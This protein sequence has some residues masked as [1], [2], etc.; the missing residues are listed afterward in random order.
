VR[1]ATIASGFPGIRNGIAFKPAGVLATALCVLK[2]AGPFVS[3]DIQFD[4]SEFLPCRPQTCGTNMQFQM[5][6]VHTVSIAAPERAPPSAARARA[7]TAPRPTPRSADTCWSS[8]TGH[9]IN[10]EPSP[11]PPST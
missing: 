7:V 5:P 1:T 11:E 10:D 2:T 9:G 4:I 8:T 3:S 6:P